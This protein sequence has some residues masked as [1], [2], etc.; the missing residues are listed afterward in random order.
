MNELFAIATLLDPRYKTRDFSK[1][2]N[3]IIAKDLLFAELFKINISV[4]WSQESQQVN[5][6][7]EQN[8]STKRNH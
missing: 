6:S 5:Y 8:S 3:V 2:K 7:D 1:R 4:S